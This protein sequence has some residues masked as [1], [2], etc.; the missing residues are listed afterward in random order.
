M[1]QLKYLNVGCGDKIHPRWENIDMVSRD[2]IV[3][4]CNLLNGIPYTDDEFEVV[5]HS[6][7]LEHFSKEDA[8][9]FLKECFR[10]LQPGGIL[11]VVVP[12]LESIAEEYLKQLRANLDGPDPQSAA[13][14]DWVMLELYDQT[15]R[16]VRGG[17]MA[18]Y[19]KQPDM[20]NEDY[21]FHRTGNVCRQIREDALRKAAQRPS[22]FEHLKQI[23]KKS[24]G[25]VRKLFVSEAR[26]I[27]AYRLGGEI[28][29]WMYD[30]YSLSRL[31]SQTGFVDIKVQNYR[32]S[33]I[34]RWNSYQLD[35]IDGEPVDRISL[36]MEARKPPSPL[37]TS[38]QPNLSR[39]AA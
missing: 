29:Q 4:K 32:E 10:V 12:D 8:P 3:K 27:G 16:N 2:P 11:R 1:S 24:I 33:D 28:H 37:I 21:V 5:Y 17:Q 7:V 35:E 13:N 22:G 18:D 15:V 19:L 26:R 34:P 31:L 20:V 9:G 23:V 14:Y 38:S 39:K 30:R 6:Q 36:Y 25:F